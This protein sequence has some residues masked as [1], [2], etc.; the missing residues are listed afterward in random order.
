M[1]QL[2]LNPIRFSGIAY[3][4]IVV[5]TGCCGRDTRPYND[6]SRDPNAYASEVKNQIV[7][8]LTKAQ[9]FPGTG[10]ERVGVLLE[11]VRVYPERSVGENEA[12]YAELLKELE[13]LQQMYQSQA[14]KAETDAKSNAIIEL[15]KTLPGELRVEDD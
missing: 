4:A 15:A 8:A 14:A 5:L 11:T 3:L 6:D 2:H 7:P 13:T 10:T 9:K 12:T 1:A